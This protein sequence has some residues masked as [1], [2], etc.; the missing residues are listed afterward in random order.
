MSFF[1]AHSITHRQMC[2]VLAILLIVCAAVVRAE[3]EYGL[4]AEFDEDNNDAFSTDFEED[5]E[6]EDWNWQVQE[7]SRDDRP[8]VLRLAVE[9]A[10]AIDEAGAVDEEHAAEIRFWGGK[11]V[12]LGGAPWLASIYGRSS[13]GEAGEGERNWVAGHVCGGVLIADHWVLT[14]AHCLLTRQDGPVDIDDLGV[15]VGSEDLSL[16][17]EGEVFRVRRA[18]VHAD[19]SRSNRAG[20]PNMY[21]ND[22][23][24]IELVDDGRERDPDLIHPVNQV[25]VDVHTGELVATSN[26][27][28]FDDDDEERERAML[29]KFEMRVPEL[30][31]CREYEGYGQPWKLHERVF[32]ADNPE[33]IVCNGD[34][35]SPVMLADGE[36]TLVGITS[37]GRD[38]CDVMNEVGVYTLVDPYVEWINAAMALPGKEPFVWF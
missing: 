4:D 21:D 27:Y 38:T 24:L 9:E 31:A 3:E 34:S 12:R 33:R 18:I 11:P 19:Y 10:A 5:P 25:G 1:P 7:S 17:D 32:C 2:A 30:N 23:G 28:R 36:P 13:L 20:A 26:W 6:G 16:Q 35:G 15:V 8:F 37:W 29:L 22:L 14:S